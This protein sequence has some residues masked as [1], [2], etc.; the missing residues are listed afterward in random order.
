MHEM[1]LT[2]SVID[3]VVKQARICEAK[4]V[5]KVNLV[6]GDLRDVV[7]SM[8]EECFRHFAVG[9]LAEG[10]TLEITHVP[11]TVRCKFC[12][13]EFVIRKECMRALRCPSCGGESFDLLTGREF[14]V[15]DIEIC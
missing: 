15:D 4:R 7:E 14:F 13:D 12:K 2:G 5:L 6:V 10:A 1:A 8:M 3:I 11:A 9:T